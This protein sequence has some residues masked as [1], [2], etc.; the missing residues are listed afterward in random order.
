MHRFWDRGRR[1]RHT[2]WLLIWPA[3]LLLCAWPPSAVKAGCIAN[4]DPEMRIFQRLIAKDATQALRQIEDRMAAV[5]VEARATQGGATTERL[6]SLYAVEAEAYGILE[7]SA[8]ARDAAAQG[9]KL[10][11][12]PRDPVRLQLLSANAENV[13]DEAGIA[14]SATDIEAARSTQ[15]SDTEAGICLLI[16]R[17]LLEHRQNRADLAIVSL[18]QAYHASAA[19]SMMEPHI[20][21]AEVLS[22]VMRVMGDYKQALAL[23]QEAVDWHAS[24]GETLSLSVARFMRGQILKLMNSYPDAIVEF[25]EA[26]KLSVL[27]DDS[28]GIAY[29][30][31]RTCE[32][33]IELGELT[34]AQGECTGAA[35]LF[36]GAASADS[37][38]AAEALLARI[39]LKSGRAE[40]AVKTL[41][42]VLDH[43]GADLPPIDVAALYE[44]RAQ[45]N[46]ALHNYRNAYSDLRE[47]AQ[48]YAASNDAELHRQAGA[49]RARFETDRQIERNASLQRELAVSQELSKRQTRQLRWNAVVAATG[50]SIIA[51]LIYFLIT[52]MR[53]R[54]RLVT[55]ASQDGLTGLPNRRRIAEFATTALETARTTGLPLTIA[56]IDMDHFKII[57]DCCGHA[58]GDYVLK[59]FARAG[60]EALRAGDLLGRWG[61]EEFLLVSP[62]S[63]IGV[64]MANLERLRTLIYRIH[65]PASGVGLR[66]SLSAGLA[67]FDPD[68]KSLDELIARADKALYAAKSAGRDRVSI[69]DATQTTGAHGARRTQRI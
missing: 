13:Y 12:N 49:L 48:R 21:S 34:A 52:N 24:Q 8:E 64:G 22:A 47:Y 27:L 61:G 68:V 36:A 37:V 59:E 7:R 18:T 54:R 60:G 5:R 69:A 23:N 4:P 67:A 40:R 6:A 17:G 58:T 1:V 11:A 53:Y 31:L 51:L 63:T 39:D 65:L 15:R 42:A 46:A 20:L 62:G 32:A 14:A 29:A 38:K 26:R 9:L 2:A 33:H 41:N 43:D 10:V 66:V 44:W 3:A 16:T 19:R 57:N 45:A 30:D 55:L 28:Q 25:S 35:L 56:L 50:V